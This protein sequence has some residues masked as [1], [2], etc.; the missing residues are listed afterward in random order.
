MLREIQHVKQERKKDRRRWFTD[1]YWDLY[2]WVR[3]DGTYSG[4][5]LCYGKTD[6]QR[7]LTWMGGRG[8]VHT[9]V[10]EGTDSAVDMSAPILVADGTLDVPGVAQRFWKESREI[11]SDVRWYVIAKM[12][13][14]M[15]SK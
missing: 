13:E 15:K 8:P 5:Q 9:G 3:K 7:A 2:V 6:R 4:F 11:D 10:H 12:K 1:D 14:L